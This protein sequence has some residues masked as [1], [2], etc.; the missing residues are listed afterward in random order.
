MTDDSTIGMDGMAWD[1]G[2]QHSLHSDD[3]FLQTG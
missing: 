1:L 3:G 2:L